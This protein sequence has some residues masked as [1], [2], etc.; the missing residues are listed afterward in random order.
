[1]QNDIYNAIIYIAEKQCSIKSQNCAFCD[2]GC[3][4]IQNKL[5]YIR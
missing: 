3:F 1:M 4:Y 2:N 5:I